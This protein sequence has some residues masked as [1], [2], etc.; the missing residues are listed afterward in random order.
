MFPIIVLESIRKHTLNYNTTLAMQNTAHL[1]PSFY[2]SL[3]LKCR[4]PFEKNLFLSAMSYRCE[5][6]V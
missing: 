3:S 5:Y 6:L 4:L 1:A 2:A